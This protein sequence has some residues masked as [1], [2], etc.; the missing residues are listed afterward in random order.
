MTR[1]WSFHTGI[2][3]ALAGV[4]APEFGGD[5]FSRWETES[6]SIQILTKEPAGTGLP[7]SPWR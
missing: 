1:T 3:G 7:L 6:Q 4:P 5:D 2:G